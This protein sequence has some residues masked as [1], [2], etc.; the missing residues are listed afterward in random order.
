MSAQTAQPPTSA[1]SA[2]TYAITGI[3]VSSVARQPLDGVKVNIATG[4]NNEFSQQVITAADGRF[5]FTGIPAGKYSLVGSAA[6]L[7]SQG[8]HQHGDFF[9]GIAVG[10]GLDSQN[11]I[12]PLVPDV[13]IEGTITDDDGEPVRNSSVALYQRKNDAGRQQ[14]RQVANENHRRPR[15]LSVRPSRAWNLLRGRVGAAVVRAIFNSRRV[16]N[17]SRIT[18]SA[19]SKKRRS[20]MSPTP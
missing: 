2:A 12:F 20:S 19:S 8:F 3:V 6:R 4:D 15:A 16:P 9:I 10:P 1:K 17:R 13:R 18:P 14:T 7:P 5:A 11:L